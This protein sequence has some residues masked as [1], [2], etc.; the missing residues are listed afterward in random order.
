MNDLASQQTSIDWI[1]LVIGVMGGLSLFLYGLFILAESLKRAAGSAMKRI[2][3][4]LTSNRFKGAAA[5]AF[6]TAVIQSS[7]VTTVLVVGFISAGLMTLS[8][9]VGV[10]MGANIGSTVTA[11]IIAFKVTKLA[12]ALIGIGGLW[13]VF[14]KKQQFKDVAIMTLGIG[15]VFFGM[16]MMSDSTYPLRS[17][18]PFI[19]LMSKMESPLA[20]ILVGALFTAVVQS[21]A[22]TMGI[23]IVLSSQGLVT[24]EAGI[25]LAFGANIGTCVTALLAGIGKPAQAVRAAVIHV[26]FNVI[27]VLLWVGFIPELVQMSEWLSHSLGQSATDQHVNIARD[28]ANAHTLFNVANTVILIGFATPLARLATWLVKDRPE[29]GHLA[30]EAQYLDDIL[31][32]TPS[33]A[34]D[35]A[36]LEL[37]RMGDRIVEMIRKAADITLMGNE[38]EL[39]QLQELDDEI[40]SLFEQI[41]R[42][43][44]KVSSQSLGREEASDLKLYLNTANVLENMGD[45]IE[46]RFVHAGFERSKL[47]EEFSAETRLLMKDLILSVIPSVEWAIEAMD[48][49]SVDKANQIRNEKGKLTI[50]ITHLQAHLAVRL[51]LSS[52]ERARVFGLESEIVESSR[53]LYDL[54]KR[55]ARSVLDRAEELERD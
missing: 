28:L 33:L 19:A 29:K 9:S 27:G 18:E 44:G 40:D 39:E 52:G 20:G 30:L 11:Q 1:A 10:I 13:F 53:R 49:K 35:R 26:L 32:E 17:F 47:H 51:S 21:S 4:R 34:L 55:I 48:T 7:S 36:R 50:N 22:A 45:L 54:S 37:I 12:T 8:E 43:L 15:L 16:T 42:Y 2:L 25:A 46:S 41:A 14:T 5:G 31:I 38:F 23:V 6:I 24:L 3:S